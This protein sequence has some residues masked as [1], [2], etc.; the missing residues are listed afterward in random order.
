MAS[1]RAK[2]F[3]NVADQPSAGDVTGGEGVIAGSGGRERR[4]AMVRRLSWCA[5]L[6]SATLR[7]LLWH[8]RC[9]RTAAV[10]VVLPAFELRELLWH[11]RCLRAGLATATL[12]GAVSGLRCGPHP[13][14]EPPGEQTEG[15]VSGLRRGPHPGGEPPG[16]QT[17][18]ARR[19]AVQVGQAAARVGAVLAIAIAVAPTPA[20]AQDAAGAPLL[21]PSPEPGEG[22]PPPRGPHQREPEPI[23]RSPTARQPRAGTPPNGDR[24]VEEFEATLPATP[25][26]LP[27]LRVRVGG[28][29]MLPTS[30]GTVPL[31]RISQE[32]EWQ[33]PSLEFISV[34]LGAAQSIGLLTLV[35]VGARG[36]GLAWF[37]EDRVVRCQGA[38]AVQVGVLAG[39]YGLHFDL[40][41]DVDLRFLFAARVELFARGSFFSVYNA[42]RDAFVSITGGAAIA[43]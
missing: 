30:G 8:R 18:G 5:D 37:C 20:L 23:L 3:R 6:T 39:G 7:E 36:A 38:I 10:F 24:D 40:Q 2:N 29:V 21:G 31:A 15:A 26:A 4:A 17:E 19:P 41:A 34:G 25:P 32:V 35:Q 16:E 1:F 13:G 14:G 27:E 22:I 43:F 33:P 12:E 28:G 9:L 11:R 42:A